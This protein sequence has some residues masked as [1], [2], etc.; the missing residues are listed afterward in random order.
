MKPIAVK[1][2]DVHA[3]PFISDSTIRFEMSIFGTIMNY[4]VKKRYVPASQRF[5]ERPKLKTMRRD[6]FTLEEYRKL[7]TVGRKWIAE[8]DKP[9]S[10][11]Y[12]TV[13]YN[14]ILIACNTGMRPAQ[15]KNLRWRTDHSYYTFS[16]SLTTPPCSEDVTWFVLKHP[17]SVSAA[18][19]EQFSKLYRNDARPDAAALWPCR[20][21]K[22]V[23]A[24]HFSTPPT[25]AGSLLIGTRGKQAPD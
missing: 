19:I 2:K 3:V 21:G 22:Q 24:S 8:A 12:R 15:M 13:T 20:F 6:E 5:D 7:H 1:P 18:E 17:V 10:V 11:W 4:A 16:G 25:A 14:M 9:S 23:S